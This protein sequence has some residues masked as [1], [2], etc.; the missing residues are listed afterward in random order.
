MKNMSYM[1]FLGWSQTNKSTT[2]NR[3]PFHYTGFLRRISI[4]VWYHPQILCSSLP[5]VPSWTT[6]VFSLLKSNNKSDPEI[7]AVRS[8]QRAPVRDTC[9]WEIYIGLNSNTVFIPKSWTFQKSFLAPFWDALPF[10][11]QTDFSS[12]LPLFRKNPMPSNP[13]CIM[14]SPCT[15]TEKVPEGSTVSR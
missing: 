5:Q 14:F 3:L 11:Q 12:P 15:A 7:L 4:M 6:R 9:T 1:C 13:S 8:Y 2:K 10:M